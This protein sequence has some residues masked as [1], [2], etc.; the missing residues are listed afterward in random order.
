MSINKYNSTTG[1]LEPVTGSRM[2]VGTK[3][4]MQAA[5]TAGTLPRDAV[6]YITDDEEPIVMQEEIRDILNVYGSKNL[7]P[8]KGAGF[9]HT[10]Y[11]VTFTVQDDGSVLVNGTATGGQAIFP[12][13][14][15]VPLK[16][17]VSYRLFGG[18]TA[19][20]FVYANAINVSTYVK[21][22]GLDIN[23][24]S[25]SY[26]KNPFTPDYVGY[27]IVEIGIAV[28]EGQTCTNE[29]FYPM[30]T[31]ESVTDKT[32]ASYAMTNQQL[33]NI[34]SKSY[35]A[36][37]T[38]IDNTQFTTIKK[39]G[40]L[41]ILTFNSNFKA[42]LPNATTTL[43]SGL[44][45]PVEQ[46]HSN[47]VSNDGLCFRIY[48]NLSGQLVADSIVSGMATTNKWFAGQVTYFTNN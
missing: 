33:T 32:Y 48:V 40:P 47:L 36:N 9:T 30:V 7:L 16:S 5:K 22:I 45:I 10:S 39:V 38:Y 25:S 15:A 14:S 35:T 23:D 2:W 37:T 29:V 26:T 8:T 3:A 11:N 6:I 27:N 42:D 4:E 19:Q 12:V 17:G 18:K 28:N 24:P 44:P 46:A 1:L 43:L 41:V 13:Y 21:T 20:K 34:Q 31:L